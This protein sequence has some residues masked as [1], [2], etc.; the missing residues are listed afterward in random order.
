MEACNR[1]LLLMMESIESLQF[2]CSC[3]IHIYHLDGAQG[4]LKKRKR[5]SARHT[6]RKY[7]LKI[8]YVLVH[9]N[10]VMDVAVISRRNSF[11][12]F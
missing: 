1:C 7:A 8:Q 2:A 4:K 11:S 3:K 10:G 12:G 6:A 5:I 9:L